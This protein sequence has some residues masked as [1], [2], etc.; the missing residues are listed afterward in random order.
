MLDRLD[1]TPPIREAP[2]VRAG[3][4]EFSSRGSGKEDSRRRLSIATRRESRDR[5]PPLAVLRLDRGR[6]LASRAGDRHWRWH[7]MTSNKV[8]SKGKT[9]VSHEA[10]ENPTA[11][12]G[13]AGFRRL[14]HSPAARCGR[15]RAVPTP[16]RLENGL[17]HWGKFTSAEHQDGCYQHHF[18]R[19]GREARG[20]GFRA[21]L[22]PQRARSMRAPA[23]P[24]AA[25]S[26]V[27][28]RRGTPP[29]GSR[30]CR[31]RGQS[32]GMT[33]IRSSSS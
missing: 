12:L 26:M 21:P 10:P 7:D 33:A 5:L 23:V 31:S 9:T 28:R 3:F 22:V 19:A 16:L 24:G 30:Y 29:S 13:S 20:E 1:L 6:V 4:R 8:T 18:L 32:H 17:L 2:P 15:G 14:L 11:L 27:L 25:I